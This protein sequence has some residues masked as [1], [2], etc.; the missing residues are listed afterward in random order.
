MALNLRNI[1]LIFSVITLKLM[2]NVNG[3]GTI[4]G[5]KNYLVVATQKFNWHKAYQACAKIGMSLAS[6]D[7]YDE[8]KELKDFLYNQSK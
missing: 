8:N 5:D 1:C 3:A 4:I 7:S 6:I 2:W